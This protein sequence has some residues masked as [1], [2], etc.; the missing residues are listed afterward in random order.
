M[1]C[2]IMN[3]VNHA[4][5]IHEYILA[6]G[7]IL[8]IGCGSHPDSSLDG[9]HHEVHA[10]RDVQIAATP[11]AKTW[12]WTEY[13]S[14]EK[15]PVGCDGTSMVAGF[16]CAGGYCDNARIYCAS[17]G[18]EGFGAYWSSYFSEETGA[19]NNFRRCEPDYW[20]VGLAC[21]GAYCDRLAIQCRYFPSASS[22]GCLWTGWISE[23]GG[24][25]L[26]FGAGYYARGMRCRG[27][28]CDNKR[29]YV[30]RT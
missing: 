6:A 21:S 8:A 11:L 12:G 23:E 25:V 17:T 20:M 9:T 5:A 1:L 13:T 19:D 14:D 3:M 27:A 29:F 30:C 4:T 16:S 10:V 24:G 26:Y 15:S 18:H 7:L 22:H 28:N 2:S